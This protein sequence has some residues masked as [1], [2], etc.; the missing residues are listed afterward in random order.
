MAK[1]SKKVEE[2]ESELLKNLKNDEKLRENP[3]FR[4][5]IV[6]MASM[7]LDDFA[8]NIYRTSIEMNE[9]IPYYSIDAWREFLNYPIVRKYVKSFKDEQINMAADQGLAGGDKGAVSIKK[10]MQEGGPQIN[11]SNLILIRLPEKRDWEE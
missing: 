8:N 7:F 6:S 5:Q 2:N 1:N 11:N 10:A 9:K 4:M 3:D